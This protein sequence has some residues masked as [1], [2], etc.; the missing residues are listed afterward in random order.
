MRVLLCICVC[1][2]DH[3]TF[4]SCICLSLFISSFLV[5]SI[6][7]FFAIIFNIPIANNPIFSQLVYFKP[8]LMVFVMF[9]LFCLTSNLS[10]PHS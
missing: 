1:N 8:T 5:L 10:T 9:S 7:L 4:S 2:S 3:H 6:S